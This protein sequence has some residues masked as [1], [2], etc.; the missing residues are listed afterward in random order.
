MTVPLVGY[1]DRF[2]ARPGERIAVKVSSQRDEPYHADL[3][4]IVHGDANP[5]GPGLKIEEIAAG[6]AGRYP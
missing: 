5:A 1:V 3:V 4:R 6:F 2:S